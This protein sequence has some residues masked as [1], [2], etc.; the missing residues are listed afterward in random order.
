M[1]KED[2]FKK[3]FLDTSLKN[4]F[5][6]EIGEGFSNPFIVEIIKNCLKDS[7]S[8]KKILFPD[9]S[10]F[11]SVSL[12]S[13]YGG[14]DKESQYVTYSFL[15]CAYLPL[16]FKKE[17]L[18]I[19]KKHGL[20]SPPKEIAYKSL[21]YIPIKNAMVE[22]L[23]A[24][25]YLVPGFLFTIAIEKQ[26]KNLIN[27]FSQN[28]ED[29]IIKTLESEGLGGW[30][31]KIAEKVL[32]ISHIVSYLIALLCHENHKVLWQTDDDAIIPN[33]EQGDK[34]AQ[35]VASLIPMYMHKNLKGFGYA[36]TFKDRNEMV[37]HDL[38]SATDLAAGAIAEAV[39]NSKMFKN[40]SNSDSSNIVEF[41]KT[42]NKHVIMDW[43]SSDGISLRKLNMAI[44]K[45]G[46]EFKYHR[47][48]IK[49]DEKY[50]I[51]NKTIKVII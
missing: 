26:I 35:I 43:I 3:Y 6:P 34:L 28:P 38:L 48:N 25:D 39:N 14:E 46:D 1:N 9:L 16:D 7:H 44:T 20:N 15:V 36:T 18:K 40:K 32:R 47:L 11:E 2:L 19:R 12:F 49:V 21:D 5:F 27:P 30:K 24:L 42:K 51:K 13:D 50:K 37:F 29:E 4:P 33:K 45:N 23:K 17:M 31:G 8:A 41:K 22:Y 10:E